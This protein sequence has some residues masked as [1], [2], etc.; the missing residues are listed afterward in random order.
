[1]T[2]IPY[3][4][5][6]KLL[7]WKQSAFA[8]AHF[9]MTKNDSKHG[10][11][12]HCIYPRQS[13]IF[14]PAHCTTPINTPCIIRYTF[15]HTQKHDARAFTRRAAVPA[16]R[17]RADRASKFLPPFYLRTS[18]HKEQPVLLSAPL[19]KRRSP[20][21]QTSTRRLEKRPPSHSP[22]PKKILSSS[23][24]PLL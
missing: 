6:Y 21:R 14:S 9:Y 8:I 13:H 3:R 24:T 5:Q 10:Q 16:A 1:M 23:R 11:P 4:L 15:T 12:F 17:L 20:I 7:L 18:P 2:K 22:R 19:S